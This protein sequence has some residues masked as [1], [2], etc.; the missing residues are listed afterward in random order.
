LLAAGAALTTGLAEGLGAGSGFFAALAG[1]AAVF[2]L[3]FEGMVK[4]RRGG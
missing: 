1:L 2:F 4:V 3:G